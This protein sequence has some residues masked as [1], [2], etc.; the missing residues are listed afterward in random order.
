ML[1]V[2]CDV[3]TSVRKV[4]VYV[5]CVCTFHVMLHCSKHVYPAVH[6]FRVSHGVRDTVLYPKWYKGLLCMHDTHAMHRVYV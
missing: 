2:M 5:M 6:H 3:Y 4:C 1:C